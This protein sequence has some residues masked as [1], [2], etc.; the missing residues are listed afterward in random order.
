MRSMDLER[1]KFSA[2]AAPALAGWCLFANCLAGAQ[3]T[4]PMPG[5]MATGYA[6]T[7]AQ[8]YSNAD[9]GAWRLLGSND[10]GGTWKVL[11]VQTNQVFKAR[12][13]RRQY[14]ISNRTGYHAYRLQIDDTP[15]VGLAEFELVGPP[16]GTTNEADLHTL[17]TASGEH[18]LLAPA[19]QAFDGDPATKWVDFGTSS[20]RPVW[21]QCEYTFRKDL[22]VM[23]ISQFQVVSRLREGRNRLLDKAPEILAKLKDKTSRSVRPLIGYALTSAN[24]APARDPRDWSLLGSSDQGRTWA[25]LDVRRNE[26]FNRRFQ[27]RSFMLPRRVAHSLYRLQIDSIRFP[28]G[29]DADS[30]QISEIEPIFAPDGPKDRFSVVVCAQGENPPMEVAEKAFD[31]DVRTKWLDFGER[32]RGAGANT[33]RASWIEWQY[34]DESDGPV[35]NLRW[36]R[37][38]RAHPPEPVRLAL[39]G[40]VVCWEPQTG[41][42]GL[43]DETGFQRFT[44]QGFAGEIEV[45]NWVSL[46]GEPTFGKEVPVVLTP[47]IACLSTLPTLPEVRGDHGMDEGVHFLLGSAEGTVESVSET[48]HWVDARLLLDNGSGRVTVR[49]LNPGSAPT[50]IARACRLRAQGVVQTVFNPLG[51][52]SCGT[53][54]VPDPNHLATVASGKTVDRQLQ[55]E[56]GTSEKRRPAVLTNI[57]EVYE[58]SQAHA[59]GGIPA[60]IRGVITYID[61][62]LNHFFVHDGADGI[63][64]NGLLRAG[65]APF[66]HQ[67]GL[68][69]EVR[70]RVATNEP[71]IDVAEVARVFGRG[72]MPEP[73][74]HSWDYL[75]TGKDFGRWVEVEGMVREVD[76]HRL[77]LAVNGGKLIVWLPEVDRQMESRLFGSLVRVCGVCAPLLNSLSTR[78]GIRLLVPSAEHLQVVT[79]APD[80]PFSLP[81]RPISRLL[82]SSVQRRTASIQLI[83]TMGV[84]TYRESR[85]IFL[86]DG[87]VGLRVSLRE[88][89]CVN[90]GDRAEAVGFTEP[91]GLSLRLVQARV[92]KLGLETLPAPVQIELLDTDSST[93]D[94]VRGWVEG[95][96]VGRGPKGGLQILEVREDKTD[97][98]FSAVFPTNQGILPPLPLGTRVR[99]QGVFKA[100]LGDLPDFGQAITTFELYGSSPEDVTVLQRPSWWTA[101]H[102]LWAVGGITGVLLLVLGWVSALRGQ[103]RARTGELR[104]EVAERKRAQEALQL[105]RARLQLHFDR[106]PIGCIM[107]NKEFQVASWNPAAQQIFGYTADDVLGKRPRGL[108]VPTECR[109]SEDE[110][111][112]RSLAA[113]NGTHSVN[114]NLTKDGRQIMC[115]WTNAPLRSNDGEVLGVLSMVQDVTD[116]KRMEADLAYERDLLGTLLENVP[117]V[118]YF[119]DKESRFVR[120]SRSFGQLF[121]LQD[122]KLLQ[123]KTDFDF[124]TREHAQPAYDDEQEIIHTGRALIGKI[125]KETHLDGR[126]TWALTNKSPWRD[127]EGKIIGTFGVSQNITAIKDTEAKLAAAQKELLE[128]SRRAGMADVASSVLHNVGNVL[129]SVNV[130]ASLVV[131]QVKHSKAASL[132]KLAALLRNHEGDLESFL[133][134]DPKGKQVPS[135]LAQLSDYIVQEQSA[136]VQELQKL[137]SYIDHIKEIVAMQQTYSK[138]SG[139]AEMVKLSDL[140]EDALRMNETAM[141]RHQIQLVR[142]LDAQLPE[143][144]LEKHKVLQILVNLVRNAKYACAESAKP[145]KQIVVRMSNGDGRIKILVGDNGVGIACENLTRIFNFGFTTRK[146]GHGFGL[147]ASALAARELGGTLRVH[148]DGPGRGATFTLEL[149]ACR[150][151]RG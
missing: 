114:R 55:V 2:V 76:E 150:K 94:A 104:T 87:D 67:E 91:D 82:R 133:T 145:D 116:R 78:L 11:D 42:L 9:P 43:L 93:T 79:A 90:V 108:I 95:M 106:M 100:D 71:A 127:R 98:T 134:Q 49:V 140:V 10:Q 74:R 81:G 36:L 124:F 25:L 147:H 83:K 35:I 148:S 58:L 50:R 102:M 84:V 121:Q 41:M 70:G 52:R 112:Y 118:I 119:K 56:D 97:R 128:T 144:S 60:R 33:N 7:S 37:S 48:A 137:T 23:T 68:Y 21:L 130:C 17:I 22:S 19:T 113:E 117:V 8:D 135:Y 122:I 30:V 129:N 125:E 46:T 29:I 103:V 141:A 45:G 14:A 6:L 136:T 80:N 110:I 20:S 101:Q 51:G 59:A 16:I 34:L 13:E 120:V 99:L 40:V 15:E 88:D 72:Q 3:P 151:A 111:W 143:L 65:L 62:G 31:G 53:I 92:R 89:A 149:P 63:Q 138:V 96:I 54:W 77:V 32:G 123:G 105:S 85:L 47:R 73:S 75:M 1:I 107:W 4:D 126:V 66:L 38:V 61:P 132:H 26:S 139:V 18:P 69:V 86:Q 146:G 64:I 115:D 27:K 24:D 28:V 131:H 57:A 142:Q 39:K 12:S 44:L 109:E 5:R